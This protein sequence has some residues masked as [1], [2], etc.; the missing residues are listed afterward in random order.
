MRSLTL[1]LEG[2]RDIRGATR[3]DIEDAVL[4]IA[5]PDGPTFIVLEDENGNYSQ[6]AG[7][8]R[9]YVIESRDSYGEGFSHWRA[10]TQPLPSGQRAQAYY[11]QSC[12][13][14]KHQPRR[15]PMTVDSTQVLGLNAAAAALLAFHATG[16]RC[17][18]FPWHDVTEQFLS[19]RCGGDGDDIIDI[20]PGS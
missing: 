20:R 11:R 19:L 16:E 8:D 10:A 12:P 13:K 1:R 2:H 14:H 6:A 9:A 18:D 7:T 5:R 15:C 4:K 17:D 3:E